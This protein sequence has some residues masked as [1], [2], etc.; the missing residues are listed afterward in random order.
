MS[1]A[2]GKILNSLEIAIQVI[3]VLISTFVS[4]FDIRCIPKQTFN[5]TELVGVADGGISQRSVPVLTTTTGDHHQD[6]EGDPA[7]DPLNAVDP[8]RDPVVASAVDLP[9]DRGPDLHD[10]AGLALPGGTAEG[11][12]GGA[13]PHAKAGRRGKADPQGGVAGGLGADPRE[14]TDLGVDPRDAAAVDLKG[15]TGPGRDPESAIGAARK[16][17][18]DRDR[19][20][21]NAAGRSLSPRSEVDPRVAQRSAA[22]PR[23]VLRWPANLDR[24]AVLLQGLFHENDPLAVIFI[25]LRKIVIYWKVRTFSSNSF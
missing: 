17:R 12:R 4:R 14:E 2:T 6:G 10:A 15:L 19:D 23:A 16:S 3:F 25:V 20:L 18:V 9:A 7:L 8:A 22:Y 1:A 24:A 13:G 21:R 5:K 11:Q